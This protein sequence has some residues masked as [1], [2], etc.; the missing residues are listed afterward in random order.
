MSTVDVVRM[1]RDRKLEEVLRLFNSGVV[2]IEQ[3]TRACEVVD[4]DY[5]EKVKFILEAN[6]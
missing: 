1:L 6:Q 4:P 3:F 2:P 5:W